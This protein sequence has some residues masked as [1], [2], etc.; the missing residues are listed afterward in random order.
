MVD[1]S[2]F[3]RYWSES[4][5]VTKTVN[6]CSTIPL[7]DGGYRMRTP[8]VFHNL[9]QQLGI[10]QLAFVPWDVH[11]DRSVYIE[12]STGAGEQNEVAADPIDLPV[13]S[14]RRR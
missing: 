7:F 1:L 14:D 11:I 13:L 12:V 9:A 3:Y 10:L 8:H 5:L 2:A 6:S 4:G